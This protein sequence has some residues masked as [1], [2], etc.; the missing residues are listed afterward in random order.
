MSVPASGTSDPTVSELTSS[1]S[2]V[3]CTC[4]AK[5]TC[6]SGRTQAEAPDRLGGAKDARERDRPEVAAVPAA[7]GTEAQDSDSSTSRDH[8]ITAS[9]S[10]RKRPRRVTFPFRPG[11]VDGGRRCRLLLIVVAPA[12]DHAAVGLDRAVVRG[13]ALA[14]R[15][16]CA[17][18]NANRMSAKGRRRIERPCRSWLNGGRRANTRMR[19]PRARSG[20]RCRPACTRASRGNGISSQTNP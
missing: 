3:P 16:A 17:G 14:T 15:A 20:A 12:H 2:E 19:A 6:R 11:A 4:T 10:A 1:T 18:A 9:I 7:I 13:V 5:N 8:G